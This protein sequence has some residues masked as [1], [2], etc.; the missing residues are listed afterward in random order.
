MTDSAIQKQIDAIKEATKKA[1]QSK[2]SAIQFL[3]NAGIMDR[4]ILK[5]SFETKQ[6]RQES[7]N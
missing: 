3:I 4:P 1:N 7:K 2:E 6:V 5:I